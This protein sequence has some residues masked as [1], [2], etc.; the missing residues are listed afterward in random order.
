M[1]EIEINIHKNFKQIGLN[2]RGATNTILS[3]LPEIDR[4]EIWKKAGFLSI[5]DYALRIAGLSNRLVNK[6]L[7][8][9]KK[10]ESMPKLK[11]L[12][13]TQGLSKL[14]IISKVA[15]I[16]TQDFW[17]SK[18]KTMTR[19]SLQKIA[20]HEKAYQKTMG[21]PLLGTTKSVKVSEVQKMAEDC[22]L[23]SFKIELTNKAKEAFFAIKKDL[24][25]LSNRDALEII[26]L[27]FQKIK[28]KLLEQ[29]T[30]IESHRP[31]FTLAK[32]NKNLSKSNHKKISQIQKLFKTKLLITINT[33]PSRHIPNIIRKS[34][35][36]TCAFPGCLHT[37]DHIH[38]PIFFSHQA[39][40]L[41]LKP[42]CTTHHK[43]LHQ[44]I[45]KN[46]SSKEDDWIYSA[47]S[48]YHP[49]NLKV[50]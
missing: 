49:L 29:K 27:E 28:L 16:E 44:G 48:T 41:N 26:L 47:C 7:E 14:E 8:V 10:L 50:A 45:V 38:H 22:G 39:N 1:T 2:R 33:K 42:L 20:L 3:M 5:Y 18:A 30:L 24:P 12:I 25:L 4:L 35:N 46:Q 36:N 17:S 11:A 32:R 15:K 31:R 37:K 43:I 19:D 34:L 9:D 40:H 6:A 13:K 23:Q 21:E